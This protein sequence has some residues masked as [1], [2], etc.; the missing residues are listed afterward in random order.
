[1]GMVR[2]EVTSGTGDDSGSGLGDEEGG[3]GV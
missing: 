3:G 2:D 1:V